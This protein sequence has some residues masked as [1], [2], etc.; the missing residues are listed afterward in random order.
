MIAFCILNYEN[1]YLSIECSESIFHANRFEP[2]DS[3]IVLIV[4]NGSKNDSFAKLTEYAENHK[5]VII[6]KTEKNLGFAEGNNYGYSF[7]KSNYLLDGICF[8]NSD[9]V[10]TDG[11]DISTLLSICTD[12][13]ASI[14]AP[15]IVNLQGI[16]QNPLRLTGITKDEIKRSIRKNSL[17]RF[18]LRIPLLSSF[19]VS[20]YQKRKSKRQSLNRTNLLDFNQN[21]FVPHGACLLFTNKWIKKESFA[22][23][24]GTFLYAEEDFLFYYCK[25]NNHIITLVPML[26]ILHKEDGSINYALRNYKKKLMFLLSNQTNSLKKLLSYLN[27]FRC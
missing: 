11:F 22:F 26:K 4:D 1:F 8:L 5:G 10:V 2:E 16:H 18:I 20:K 7:L 12:N 15:D 24:P 14:I 9:T 13:E 23:V 19:F 21:S 6:I 3:F 25:T 27:T 17:I